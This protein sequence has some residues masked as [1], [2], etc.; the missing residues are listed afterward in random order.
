VWVSEI[1]LQQ[2]TVVAVVPYYERFLARFPT[3][4]DLAAAR[5]DEVLKLWEGLGYYS[6][7]RNMRRAAQA[8]VGEYGGRFPDDLAALRSLPGIGRYTAG[9]IVS[10]AFDRPAAI[11]EAN[12]ARLYARLLGFAGDP[13]SA[14][15][16]RLL[17]EF[18]E[19]LANCREPGRI[20][21]ALMELGAT[22][23]TPAAPDCPACP[24]SGWCRAFAE[25]TQAG[26]PRPTPRPEV[27]QVVEAA[28]AV[29]KNG[30]VLLRRWQAGEWWAGLW[31]FPR[32]RLDAGNGSDAAPLLADRV[33]DELGLR[34]EVGE[35]LGG[36]THSVTR[37]RIRLECFAAE[38]R[39]GRIKRGAELEWVRPRDLGD[40]ALSKPGRRM[41]DLL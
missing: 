31:D 39:G 17:W 5:E 30:N 32:V 21:Q 29:R 23:C 20:N 19:A 16:Q 10:F 26:I 14:D 34:I 15:G 22:L 13:K 40:Y 3:L 41:A 38:F 25:G 27:T 9:A 28:V 12:T 33:A 18:A 11:V 36:F 37:Y 1:M 2:T 7:A 4:R 35:R 24:V 6:R 8:I